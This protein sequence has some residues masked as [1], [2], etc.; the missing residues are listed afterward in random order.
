MPTTEVAHFYPGFVLKNF[1]FLRKRFR[2]G[3]S[4]KNGDR[5]VGNIADQA[6]VKNFP[7]NICNILKII[8]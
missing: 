2:E 4:K 1:V 7:V 3:V 8:A 6:V 5:R